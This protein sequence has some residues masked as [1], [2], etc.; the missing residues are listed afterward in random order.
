MNTCYFTPG[1][2]I[3]KMSKSK[4]YKPLQL[5]KI[6]KIE[7]QVGGNYY[8]GFTLTYIATILSQDANSSYDDT[9]EFYIQY[10][11]DSH[12]INMRYALI[13]TDPYIFNTD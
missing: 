3:Y 1:D 9:E 2:Y 8:D 10:R 12:N 6:L 4:I 13:A 5:Y 7:E 11:H